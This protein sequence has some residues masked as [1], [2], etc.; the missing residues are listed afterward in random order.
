[1]TKPPRLKTCKHC[2]NSFIPTRPMQTTCGYLCALEHAKEKAKTQQGKDKRK[3]IKQFK[4]SDLATLKR[5]AETV[6]N[7][8]IRERDGK[9]CISCGY[10]GNSRQFHAG[11]YLP[12]GNNSFLR[13]NEDNIHSQCS[14]C[15]NHLSGNLAMYR[16]NLIKKIGLE[17]VEW[18][19][20]QRGVTKKWTIEELKEIIKTHKIKAKDIESKEMYA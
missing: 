8:Y 10:K 6:V 2:K 15:N 17:K 11:H 1:M 9:V 19:E 16:I 14:I 18:L 20:S 4:D 7:K 3:A 5:L 13:Y 12:K